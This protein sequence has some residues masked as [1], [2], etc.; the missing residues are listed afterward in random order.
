M[1]K[2]LL[3]QEVDPKRSLAN[4]LA[5]VGDRQRS[6]S[7]RDARQ[8]ASRKEFHRQVRP[9]RLLAGSEHLDQ[10][11]MAQPE[12]QLSFAAE[13]PL[14]FDAVLAVRRDDL[15]RHRASRRSL[16][17]PIHGPHAADVHPFEDFE[18]AQLFREVRQPGESPRVRIR[19]PLDDIVASRRRYR[20]RLDGRGEESSKLSGARLNQLQF[21][22]VRHRRKRKAIPQQSDFG[23]QIGV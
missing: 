5:G 6:L 11:R 14:S 12:R 23:R 19:E 13:T 17:S 1:H 8:V 10:M 7:S 22:L 3:V 2:A 16:P 15:D 4:Q 20:T 21:R 9:P 18:I